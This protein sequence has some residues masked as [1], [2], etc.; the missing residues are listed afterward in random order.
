[1]EKVQAMKSASAIMKDI[2]D[3]S[4]KMGLKAAT[5]EVFD[6]DEFELK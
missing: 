4:E 2:L 3:R 5:K 6:S 1:V